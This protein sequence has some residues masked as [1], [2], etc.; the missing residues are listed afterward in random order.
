MKKDLLVHI[1]LIG[2]VLN[3]ISL[4]AQKIDS[5][6]AVC[7]NHVLIYLDSATYQKLFNL[8]FLSDT[9]GNCS[10]KTQKTVDNEWSG[11]YL[12]GE[13]GYLEF[14]PTKKVN[15]I[16]SGW[17]GFGF[18]TFRS[19]DIWK[20]RDK[21]QKHTTEIIW[22]DTSIYEDKGTKKSWFYSISLAPDDTNKYLPVWLMENTPEE[23]K[24]AGYG[25]SDLKEEIT[26]GTYMNNL[27]SQ[28]FSKL[29]KGITS[30]NIS[31]GTNEM[32]FLQKIMIGFG[33]H[34]TDSTFSNQYV[35]ILCDIRPYSIW[36]IQS[37]TFELKQDVAYR[38]LIISGS[39][40]LELKGK[41][42]VMTFN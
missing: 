27:K 19:G 32:D 33:L 22:T 42:A 10:T 13:E 25:D 16:P 29:L 18:I 40:I 21:W 6:P 9:V 41:S 15:N 8:S 34:K 1:I 2:L 31:V 26:W 38:K 11:K 24:R 20:I 7:L 37:V 39:L 28:P 17:F 30:V 3:C 12:F 14:F 4:S 36:R 23:M 35:D 5:I